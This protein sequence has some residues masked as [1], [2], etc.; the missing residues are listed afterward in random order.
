MALPN[1]TTDRVVGF[2]EEV[3]EEYGAKKP[4]TKKL[5]GFHRLGLHPSVLK[6]VQ[7]RGYKTPTPIQRKV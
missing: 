5:G 6:G 4:S 7:K 3:E 2:D 1:P